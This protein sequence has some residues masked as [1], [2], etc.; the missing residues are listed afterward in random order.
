MNKKFFI[1]LIVLLV[2]SSFVCSM[3]TSP[4]AIDTISY[5]GYDT[6]VINTDDYT[7]NNNDGSFTGTPVFTSA[8]KYLGAYRYDGTI[9]SFKTN[10][11]THYN[12][13]SNDFAFSFWVNIT[14][15]YGAV[16]TIFSDSTTDTSG[17]FSIIL[18]F[19]S[20]VNQYRIYTTGDATWRF[21][22]TVSISDYN[23]IV[24]TRNSG[25]LKLYIDN[26][27]EISWT[28][29]SNLG[30]ATRPFTF[31]RRFDITQTASGGYFDELS[32]FNNSL[33]VNNVEFLYS[34]GSPTEQQ[35]YPFSTPSTPVEITARNEF[36]LTNI[37]S[38]N[39]TIFNS[40]N[41][42]FVETTN[43]SVFY[44]RNE[45]VNITIRSNNYFNKT[46][47]NYN[48]SID[49]IVDMTPFFYIESIDY[50]DFELYSGNNYTR[51]LGT[52][53]TIICHED[54]VTRVLSFINNTLFSEEDLA[55]TN[56]LNNY[57]FINKYTSEGVFNISFNISN[58]DSIP[59]V[60]GTSNQTFIWDL[61]NPITI[62]D[63]E[64]VN[65]FDK[66]G[67]VTLYCEDSI[68]PIITYNN[69]FNDNLLFLGNQTNATTISNITILN[70]GLNTLVSECSDF[71]G[72]TQDLN[73]ETLT[74]KT[75]KLWDEV[76]NSI[77]DISN[78]T[79]ARIYL[80]DTFFYDLKGNNTSEINFTSLNQTQTRI[81]LGYED[82]TEI[83]RFID[84]SIVLQDPVKVCANKQ[85]VTHYEQLV[86]GGTERL[87]VI[88]N[89]FSEC[90]VAADYTRFVFE[91]TLTLKYFTINA[92][93]HLITT[94]SG[95]N[96]AILASVDGSISSTVNIDVVEFVKRG[97][98]F[99]ILGEGLSFEVQSNDTVIVY[100]NN[101]ANNSILSTIEIVN[102][103]DGQVIFTQDIISTPN[104]FSTIFDYGTINVGNNTIFKVS[105]TKTTS[106][107]SQETI[108]NYFNP[109][110]ESG[111]LT[112]EFV[113]IIALAIFIFGVTF[114]S[115]N[116]TFSWFGIIVDIAAI[117]F[118]TLGVQVWY[119]ILLESMFALFL[120]YKVLFMI[121]K[122]PQ[123]VS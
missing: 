73:A 93:Y 58:S 36:N 14:D 62:G 10:S 95:G 55:C 8:G 47:L 35:Q 37:N 59:N 12:L 99:S 31:F 120:I 3:S 118:C 116:E 46:I 2:F 1:F 30:S 81:I 121:F 44:N 38:F 43:G 4:N 87:A 27:E 75:F 32:I 112:P 85:G 110:G 82:G 71:F 63:F 15:E 105:V 72:T 66:Q 78:L 88:K 53:I 57:T 23:H 5:F 92:I 76:D 90:F 113:A 117:G 33:S 25:L 114:V 108:I 39:A 97:Y 9:N 21:S 98:D 13:G 41:E 74:Q 96:Q 6:T 68:S 70:N 77:F 26:V 102:L 28:D 65:N 119:I 11:G 94:D 60:T 123:T 89:S 22:S 48:T 109:S 101:Q 18:A 84:A 29:N 64:I 34:S 50:F 52:N 42:T 100:Y 67:N 49:L 7:P 45:V 61:V 51:S 69:T 83:T 17:D 122:N 104:S 56:S 103:D 91:D 115:S 107:L 40:T 54:S 106:D 86:F 80:T 20:T 111:F 24:I 79:S 16:D 19:D